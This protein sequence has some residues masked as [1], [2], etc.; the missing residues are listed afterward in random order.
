M[1]TPHRTAALLAAVVLTAA[2]C[3]SG[4]DTPAASTSP[5]PADSGTVTAGPTAGP[6]ASAPA[7]PG[8]GGALPA[9]LR[10][11]PEVAAAIADTASRA[12][13]APDEVLIAA[14]SP[15]TWNDGSLGCPQKGM[16]YT[17]A[18]VEGELLMLRVEQSLFQYHSARGGPF[19]YC[20]APDASYS[21]TG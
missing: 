17:Q 8:T 12:N 11:R 16:V 3:A 6:T 18:L 13:V 4:G 1:S 9:D 19:T 5:S 20:A 14:W 7:S 10:T 21:I 15:V 2:A